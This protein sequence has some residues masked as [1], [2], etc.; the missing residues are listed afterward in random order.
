MRLG[1]MIGYAGRKVTLPMDVIKT[2]D[3]LG[4]YAV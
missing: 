1:I 3:E 2:A 4:V